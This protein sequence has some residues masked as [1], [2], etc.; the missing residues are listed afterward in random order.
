MLKHEKR[1]RNVL[2]KEEGLAKKTYYEMT[3]VPIPIIVKYWRS[4]LGMELRS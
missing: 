2:S 3:A 1:V 4:N